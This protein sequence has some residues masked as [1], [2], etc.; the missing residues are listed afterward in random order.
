MFAHEAAF[1][2]PRAAFS[3]FAE[4]L[5]VEAASYS[6]SSAEP[7]TVTPALDAAS[8][9]SDLALMPLTDT[10]AALAASISMPWQ[11]QSCYTLKQEADE[12]SISTLLALIELKVTLA[13]ED[14]FR[15]R[16]PLSAYSPLT[17]ISAAEA[18]VSSLTAGPLI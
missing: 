18:A 7:E 8:T 2:T 10:D 12:A 3:P 1:A 14:V 11:V 16:L 13:A 17:L 15:S 9:S 5:A 6:T 4:I